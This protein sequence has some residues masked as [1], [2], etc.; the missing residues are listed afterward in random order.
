VTPCGTSGAPSA[1]CVDERGVHD[2]DRKCPSTRM[3][4]PVV[5][6]LAT[7]QRKTVVNATSFGVGDAFGGGQLLG[8]GSQERYGSALIGLGGPNWSAPQASVADETTWTRPRN[9]LTDSVR[10]ATISADRRRVNPANRTRGPRSGWLRRRC[11]P[12]PVRMGGHV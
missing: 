2:E 3:S 5:L 9:R 10:R 7:E 6:V 11:S 12:P 8:Q 4:S 1:G